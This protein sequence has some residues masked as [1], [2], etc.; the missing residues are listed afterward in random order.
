[1]DS[2]RGDLA[3]FIKLWVNGINRDQTMSGSKPFLLLAGAR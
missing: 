3:S 2:H 1:M